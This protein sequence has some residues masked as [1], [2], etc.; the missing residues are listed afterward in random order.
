MI[1][2]PCASTAYATIIRPGELLFAICTFSTAPFEDLPESLIVERHSVQL[3]FS[4]R[5]ASSSGWNVGLF[6]SN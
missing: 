2:L 6:Y 5:I 3:P 1:H 4:F